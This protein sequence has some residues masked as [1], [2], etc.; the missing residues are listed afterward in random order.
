MI[1][2]AATDDDEDAGT[3]GGSSTGDGSGDHAPTPVANQ[4][5]LLIDATCVPGDIR[6]PTDLSLLNE[7]REVTEKLIDAMHPP[8]R[9][10]FGQK[11]RTHRKNARHQFLAVAK[12]KRPRIS[13][14]RT[15]IKQQLGHLEQNLASIDALFACGGYLLA[16]GRYWYR[17]PLVVSEL[18]RQAENDLPLR[19]QEHP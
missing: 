8:I 7:A 6:Y 5:T 9:E 18:V 14:I 10:A 11:P 19:Q 2:S 1:Q 17:K 13:K 16:A 15:A 3:G 12:K 4:G